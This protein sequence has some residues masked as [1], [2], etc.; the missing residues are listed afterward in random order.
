M[1]YRVWNFWMDENWYREGSLLHMPCC[2]TLTG[3]HLYSKTYWITQWSYISSKKFCKTRSKYRYID[4][5]PSRRNMPQ[6]IFIFRQWRACFEFAK[7][8]RMTYGHDDLFWNPHYVGGKIYVWVWSMVPVFFCNLYTFRVFFSVMRA[9]HFRRALNILDMD[10]PVSI[11][12][13]NPNGLNEMKNDSAMIFKDTNDQ[14]RT[15]TEKREG[16]N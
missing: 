11:V 9:V 14:K 5:L 6:Y 7:H 3:F 10:C 1:T 8:L 12:D 16:E 13:G 2:F 4:R 15:R